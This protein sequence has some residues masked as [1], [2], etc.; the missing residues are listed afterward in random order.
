MPTIK[1]A[2][3]RMRQSR[4]NRIR[5]VS[6]KSALRTLRRRFDDSIGKGDPAA[7]DT[8]YRAYCSALDKAVKRGI[9]KKN[10]AIRRKR[11]AAA[12]LVAAAAA[13]APQA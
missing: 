8:Q 6:A 7:T 9:I 2:E 1:S 3:K 10:T 12:Q 4:Q 5:N 13:A 11:R